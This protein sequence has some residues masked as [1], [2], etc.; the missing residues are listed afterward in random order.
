M[1]VFFAR[2][3]RCP[4]DIRCLDSARP[5]IASGIGCPRRRYDRMEML[6][7]HEPLVGPEPKYVLAVGMSVSGVDLTEACA[8]FDRRC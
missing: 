7:A 1:N 2:S 3:V 8:R 5:G 4:L 6:F